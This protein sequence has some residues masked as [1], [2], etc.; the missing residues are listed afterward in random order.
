[1]ATGGISARYRRQE[2]QRQNAVP[3]ATPSYI[4]LATVLTTGEDK[5]H[6]LIQNDR[7]RV[8]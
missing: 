3:P 2:K 1:M 6:G 8:L 4:P 5:D 7:E